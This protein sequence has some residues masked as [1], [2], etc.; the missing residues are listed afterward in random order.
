MAH[1]AAPEACATDSGMSLGSWNAPAHV[2][3]GLGCRQ[4][5]KPVGL[6]EAELVEVE[7]Q[8]P[9]HFPHAHRNAADPL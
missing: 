1:A 6:R 4:G 9:R 8:R 5:R 2:N 7:P 3:A